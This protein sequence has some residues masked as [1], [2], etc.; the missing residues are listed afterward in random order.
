MRP[1]SGTFENPATEPPTAHL[2]SNGNYGVMLTATGEGFSRWRDMAITRW[3]AE[4]AQAALGS[5]LFLRDTASGEVWSAGVQPTRAGADRHRAVFCE[6]HAA[7]THQ[8]PRLTTMTEVVVSAE[9]DAEARRV[10]LTNSGRRAREID[11]TSY[12]ELVLAPPSADQAHPAFSKMFVVTD[13]LP[14]LGVIIATRRRRSPTDPEVWAAHIAVV[15]GEDTAPIQIETDRAKFHRAWARHRHGSDDRPAAV[16]DHR[17]CAGPDLLDPS[18]CQRTC[19]RHHARDLL[20]HGGRY[21]GCASRSGGSAPRPVCLRACRDARL[22]TGTGAVAP[23]W[24]YP[25]RC[26]RF[27]DPGRHADAQR[28]PLARLARADHRRARRPSPRS[29]RLGISGDLPIVLLQI[30][31][32]ED[33]AVLH[34]AISA[35][36]YWQMHQHA[37]DLVVLNDRTSS[38]VQDLQIAIE[39]AVRAARSRPR[40]TDIRAPV[41][42]TIH[43]LRDGPSRRRCARATHLGGARHSGGQPGRSCQPAG[44]TSRHCRQLGLQASLLPGAAPPPPALPQLEFFNGTGGFDLDGRE[45]VTILQGGQTTPAPWINVIANPSF[46]FQVSAEGSGHIWSENSRENQITPWSNDPVC[47]PSGEA[48][49]LHDLETGQVWTPTALPIRGPVL[50]LM[51]PIGGNLNLL[52]LLPD[53]T[54]EPVVSPR[55]A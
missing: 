31:D 32:A 17:H 39:S 21:A 55:I 14:E 48:I 54:V 42:G 23:S 47:D 10:T 6:H 49:Y 37:V 46:G 33:I 45:Y 40:A 26:R 18:P 11:V 1:P 2:L 9:D 3:R 53:S 25:R 16:R 13:Y 7:F 36:E 22:D 41:N 34:Q 24:H 4:A 12:A 52:A 35:H 44:A 15:E 19:W 20:D 5:F 8:M 27:P 51:D 30:D 43:A 50:D 38:Y 29:G 28:R